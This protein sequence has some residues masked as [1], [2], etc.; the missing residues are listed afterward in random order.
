MRKKIKRCKIEEEQK[1]NKEQNAPHP[2]TMSF[3]KKK[4][5]IRGNY[6]RN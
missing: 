3:R 1:K 4:E 6:Q 2:T 5:I